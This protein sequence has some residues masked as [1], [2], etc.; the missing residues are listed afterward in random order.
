MEPF[1]LVFMIVSM[2]AVTALAAYTLSRTMRAGSPK[3]DD[4]D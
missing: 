1:A 2:T 4:E 3:S